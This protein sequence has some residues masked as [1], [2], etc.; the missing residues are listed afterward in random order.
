MY[1]RFLKLNPYL[2]LNPT[3]PHCTLFIL[4][5]ALYRAHSKKTCHFQRS[6]DRMK[7]FLK[8]I[9]MR[10]LLRVELAVSLLLSLDL[11]RWQL[12]WATPKKSTKLFRCE[13]FCHSRLIVVHWI[14][15][16]RSTTT[17]LRTVRTN[18]TFVAVSFRCFFVCNLMLGKRN[19]ASNKVFDFL[20]WEEFYF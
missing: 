20:S 16:K 10:L 11:T 5:Q 3:K 1:I 7:L 4:L 2:K 19:N 17:S 12:L 14:D 13:T 15:T 6:C 9:W 8:E 18:L